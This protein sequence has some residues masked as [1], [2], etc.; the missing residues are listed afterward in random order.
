MEGFELI[1]ALG[2][3]VVLGI[4]I[5]AYWSMAKRKRLGRKKKEFFSQT[6]SSI[7]SLPYRD[8]VIQCD[9]LLDQILSA[10]GYSGSLGEK[11]KK[12]PV[13]IEN[14]INVVWRLHKL[15]N[16]LV[17]SFEQ[18]SEVLMK[19]ESA[20]YIRLLGNTLEKL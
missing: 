7:T 14:E 9:I 20:A 16:T 6:L 2:L 13:C 1:G 11:L 5:L 8:Q 4:A 17:H 12:N 19:K 10:L 18:Q 15:R 3:I